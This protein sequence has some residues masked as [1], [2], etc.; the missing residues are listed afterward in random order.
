MQEAERRMT[1]IG[2][3]VLNY[4]QVHGTLPQSAQPLVAGG[5]PQS[6]R[7]TILS[8]LGAPM[9]R[10]TLELSQPWDSPANLEV[11]RRA[12]A[13]SNWI[14]H[15]PFDSSP[16]DRT[17]F[18][19]VTG[20]NTVFDGQRAR[21]IREARR[22]MLKTA[23][24]I[25]VRDSDIA[26]HEPRDVTIDEAVREVRERPAHAEGSHV[27]LIDGVV[28]FLK[29][30]TDEDVIRYLFDQQATMPVRRT[31]MDGNV[32]EEERPE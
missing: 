31:D 27:L 32:I 15:L 21:R 7:T 5:P 23:I 20:P 12:A 28:K 10:V 29:S 2:K 11:A 13:D 6:W 25:E 4:A 8:E 24:A 16:A 3:A 26:W 17:S 1:A 9:R 22:G 14:W 30:N 18:V 19:L